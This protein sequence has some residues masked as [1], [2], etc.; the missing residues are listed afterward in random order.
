MKFGTGEEALVL[1]PEIIYEDKNFLAVNKP[2]GML[3]HVA[4]THAD[5]TRTDAENNSRFTI[6]SEGGSAFGGQ[7]SRERTLVDWLLEK[8]PE[9]KGVGDPLA[10]STSSLQASSGQVIFDRPGI[11][12][13]LDKDTSGV[14]LVARNQ[15]Y[16]EYLKKLFAEH[17]IQKT[18]LALVYGAPR[19]KK[20]RIDKPIALKSGTTK[21]TVHGGKME[22]EALTNYELVRNIKYQIT[23]NKKSENAVSLLRVMPKTGRTHQIRVHLAS[24]GCPVLN[25]PIYAPKKEK[26][27]TG[28]LML[29]ALSVEFTSKD[30]KKVFI[31]SEEPAE[32]KELSRY[33]T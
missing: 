17:K 31:E 11:V 14:I 9:I 28:R 5:G 30:G 24:I 4:R 29:H 32:F 7:D 2:A 15:E 26:L 13:R 18:Y 3:T 25:D 12:H 16:F 8:H 21:R 23:N 27:G 20:G 22:K 6:S 10:D 1:E 33:G 19:E